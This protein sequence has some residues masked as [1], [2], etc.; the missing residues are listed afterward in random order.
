M[1]YLAHM[2]RGKRGAI[3]T[4]ALQQR[5]YTII[6]VMIFLAVSAALFT[7]TMLFLAG[8]QQKAEFVNAVRDFETKMIDVANDV[9]NGYYQTA[10]DVSC[11]ASGTPQ[12]TPAPQ[13][14]NQNCIFLGR[15]IKF[16]SGTDR[17]QF[18]VYTLAGKRITTQGTDVQTLAEASPK[19]L[20]TGNSPPDESLVEQT[21][22]GYGAHIACV[23]IGDHCDKTHVDNAAIAFVTNLTGGISAN[24]PGGAITA[25]S[26]YYPTINFDDSISP[27]V[28]VSSPTKINT[29]LTICLLSGATN[30]YALV[31]IGTQNGGN[32]NISS[33]IKEGDTCA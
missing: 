22:F 23:G 30:Q 11:D 24:A 9:S 28:N 33:V 19:L 5:G 17:E 6:E 4:R 27:S 18:G 1:L 8:R 3:A 15:F 14:T 26:Y 7:G 12:N 32:T 16:S 29:K 2:N 10:S 31:S 21:S 20:L 13:G 25:D